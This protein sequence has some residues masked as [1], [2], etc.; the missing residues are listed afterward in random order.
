MITAPPTRRAQKEENNYAILYANEKLVFD[1]SDAHNCVYDPAK[2][3][4]F[5][6]QP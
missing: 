3:E 2:I 1:F 6:G 4:L 5:S